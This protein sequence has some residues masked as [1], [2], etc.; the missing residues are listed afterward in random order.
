MLD[1]EKN[2]DLIAYDQ[3]LSALLPL[4]YIPMYTSGAT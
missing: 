4:Y 3:L 2:P 1:S